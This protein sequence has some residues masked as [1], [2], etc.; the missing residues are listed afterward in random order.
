MI[1]QE[2]K[3]IL[4]PPI[5]EDRV[6]FPNLNGLRFFA[7]LLVIIEHVELVKFK[8]LDMDYFQLFRNRGTGELGVVMF[9]VLSGFLIT[10]L[11]L[12][13]KDKTKKISIKGF[14][15]RR[16]LRI[17][18]LY[19]FLVFLSF[20]VLR[21]IPFFDI[22]STESIFTLENFLLYLFILPNV[23]L[24]GLDSAMPYL[25]I[26]W[27]IGVEEQFYIIWPVLMKFIKN[28]QRLL[29]GVLFIYLLVHLVV[30]PVL[31]YVTNENSCISSI[32]AVWDRFNID[33]MAIGGLFA[34]WHFNKK[35]ILK[36][37]YNPSLNWCLVLF[38]IVALFTNFRLP[39]L[40]SEF[41]AVIFGILILNLAT[42]PNPILNLEN[43]PF[44]YLG[45]ISY[46]LYMYHL[47]AIVISLKVLDYMGI[48]RWQIQTLCSI[49]VTILMAT[50][51]YYGFE[52]RFIRMKTRFSKIITGDN[53]RK[54]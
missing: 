13:E 25:G 39:Y 33:C 31:M 35:S 40:N 43:K 24:F 5:K 49:G 46:G 38:F 27:S 26:T 30:L 19:Y 41:F 50:L 22:I 29:F 2:R 47:I 21:N 23:V 44:N 42:N 1:G 8:Y 10:Y 17:W 37:L 6:Y 53:V 54:S 11:L 36:Y 18:P 14:Y 48:H 9:F 20:F 45:K 3:T 52:Q 15:M 4:I 7:A 12:V 32:Q 28:K 51:S 16:I 34:L